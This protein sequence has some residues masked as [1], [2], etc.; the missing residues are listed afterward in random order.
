MKFLSGIALSTIIVF[1]C[2]TRDKKESILPENKM[3][4]VMWDMIR[5][6]QYVSDFL[7]RDSTKNKKE[8]SEKLYEQIFYLHKITRDE[9]KKSLDY[10]SARPNLFQPIIDS[11]AL[12]RNEFLPPSNH[13]IMTDSALKIKQ[14]F[15]HRYLP[16]R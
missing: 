5:A 15:Q 6:D 12:H 9:F 3:R 14:S 16:K 4:A 1:S 2:G 10:Y 11:L 13:P 7:L 8:E